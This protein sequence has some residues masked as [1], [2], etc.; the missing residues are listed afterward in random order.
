MLSQ[1][2]FLRS[3]DLPF[4]AAAC[5]LQDWWAAEELDGVAALGASVSMGPISIE[6]GVATAGLVV[7]RGW[8]PVRRT[9]RMD[10]ELAPWSARHPLTRMELVARQRVRTGRRYFRAGHRVLDGVIAEL[11]RRGAPLDTGV[12]ASCGAC[13]EGLGRLAG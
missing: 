2:S 7:R 6:P 5:R 11:S 3:L 8:G 9:V 1:A 12:V 4:A 10:L 13:K